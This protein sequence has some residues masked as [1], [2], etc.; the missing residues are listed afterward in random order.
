MPQ[1]LERRGILDVFP[2]FQT[3]AAQAAGNRTPAG[4]CGQE[5]AHATEKS[6][7]IRKYSLRPFPCLTELLLRKNCVAPVGEKFAWDFCLSRRRWAGAHQ[8]EKGK[9]HR[10]EPQTG[11]RR[12]IP[13]SLGKRAAHPPQ[14]ICSEFP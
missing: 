6:L 11:G 3:V 10:K 7:A 14:T 2:T 1:S 8:G 13:G 5:F 12:P 4:F 9:K